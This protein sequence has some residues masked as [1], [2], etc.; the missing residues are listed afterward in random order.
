[1][2]PGQELHLDHVDG[3]APDEY[4]GFSHASCNSSA[5]AQLGHWLRAFAESPVPSMTAGVRLRM[6]RDP[7]PRPAGITH[8]DG[9]DCQDVAHRFGCWP[10]QCW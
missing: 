6:P 3:G 2:R 7:G 5:G 10:T 9:C 4:L 8:R 1:M